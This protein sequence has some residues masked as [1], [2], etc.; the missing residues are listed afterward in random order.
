MSDSDEPG[1]PA[2][3]SAVAVVLLMAGCGLALLVLARHPADGEAAVAEL[4]GLWRPLIA[5][6]G[7][8]ALALL[9]AWLAGQRGRSPWAWLAVGLLLGPFALLA[10][11]LAP[12]RLR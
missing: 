11:G 3:A 8:S 2:L 10:V 5:L 9:T 7:W 6:A 1:L 12:P 4:L